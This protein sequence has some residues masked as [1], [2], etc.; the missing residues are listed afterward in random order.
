MTRNIVVCLIVAVML[1]AAQRAPA[2][3]IEESP[4]PAST[5][6]APPKSKS[7]PKPKSKVAASPK[8][9]PISFAGVWQTNFNNELRVSQAGDHV[10]GLYDG[11]S[12]VL[13]GTIN[14]N[15]LTGTW[16][17]KN[18]TG[19]FRFSL[20]GDGNSFTGTWTRSNGYGGPWT[21]VRKSR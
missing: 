12:G 11:R 17:W 6:K 20:S 8:P 7:E 2:P 3:I 21:G 10:T 15:V 19:V 1:T 13:E 9:A 16:S 18:Q 4:T 5:P 14:G